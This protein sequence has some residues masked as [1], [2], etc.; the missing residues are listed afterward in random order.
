MYQRQCDAFLQELDNAEQKEVEDDSVRED[1]LWRVNTEVHDPD[2]GMVSA[3]ALL[4]SK[5][6]QLHVC[7]V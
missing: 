2:I 6:G 1:M 4:V 5:L 7:S 3:S